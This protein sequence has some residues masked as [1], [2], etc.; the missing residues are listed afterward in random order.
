[1]LFGPAV[2]PIKNDEKDKEHLEAMRMF[3]KYDCDVKEDCE[4]R[5]K[6]FGV[7][8]HFDSHH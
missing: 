7:Y 3:G 6:K 2:L 4:W 8:I 5:F 1:M